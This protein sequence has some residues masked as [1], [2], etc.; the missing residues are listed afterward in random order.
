M[1]RTLKDQPDS[2]KFGVD[3]DGWTYYNRQKPKKRHPQ[4]LRNRH[5]ACHNGKKCCGVSP[6]VYSARAIE[7]RTWKTQE[8]G[9]Y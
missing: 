4:L 3:E 8:N 2:V 9:A 1:S 7:K 6:S 5:F